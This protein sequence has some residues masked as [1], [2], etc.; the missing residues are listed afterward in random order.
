MYKSTLEIS[1]SHFL[2][3]CRD[4]RAFSY[5]IIPELLGQVICLMIDASSLPAYVWHAFNTPHPLINLRLLHIPTLC[6]NVSGGSLFRIGI[7]TL[8]FLLP[9]LSVSKP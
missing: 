5:L 3:T 1:F 6:M 4:V 8:P 9:L 2:R 7:G